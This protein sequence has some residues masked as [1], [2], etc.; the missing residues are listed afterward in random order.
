MNIFHHSQF[1]ELTHSL[2]LDPSGLNSV[3]DVPTY[4]TRLSNDKAFTDV[5]GDISRNHAMIRRS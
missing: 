5:Q 2:G 3:F 4:N 1:M